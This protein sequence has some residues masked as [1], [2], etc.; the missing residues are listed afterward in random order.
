M[1]IVRSNLCIPLSDLKS[2]ND[3]T[4]M[5]VETISRPSTVF[6]ESCV[7]CGVFGVQD[8]SGYA[9]FG[10]TRVL[11]QIHGP[12]SDEKWEEAYARV[13]V[14][15]NGVDEQKNAEIRPQFFSALSAVIFVDKYPGKAIDI[16]ITVLSDD[17]G[18]LA[19]GLIAG[20]LALAHSGIENMG[21]M[22]SVHVAMCADGSFMTDPSH[23]EM[24]KHHSKGGITFAFV[25][26]LNQVTCID[27]YG[28]IPHQS[29]ESLTSF[30]K[31]RAISLI[32]TLHKAILNSVR[33][34]NAS[35]C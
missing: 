5:E 1:P 12:E 27:V 29:I 19:V 31:E 7:K 20:S 4:S 24:E 2:V 6:R 33:E 11:A 23:K 25:P 15:L 13:T 18:A 26:N 35:N 16:E 21:L 8:G 9:E 22:S 32:P 3:G 28:R 17:G 34:R 30:A 14:S 10:N